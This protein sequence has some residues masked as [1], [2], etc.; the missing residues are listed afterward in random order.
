MKHSV[1]IL[2]HPLKVQNY[3]PKAAT[4]PTNKESYLLP[5]KVHVT[6]I[7]STSFS[8]GC[9]EVGARLSVGVLSERFNV[10]ARAVLWLETEMTVEL[11]FV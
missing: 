5:L 9:Q 7:C 8:T 3:K 10:P 11:L 1:R 2:Q 6:W 4:V